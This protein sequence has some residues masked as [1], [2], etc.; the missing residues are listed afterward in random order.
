MHALHPL[1][2]AAFA[3]PIGAV[4]SRFEAFMAPEID[5]VDDPR[6]VSAFRDLA[7][8]TIV[9]AEQ[10]AYTSANQPFPSYINA[11]VSTDGAYMIVTVRSQAVRGDEADESPEA[12]C[13]AQIP[14]PI[15]E[16]DQFVAQATVIRQR[17]SD[18]P[19]AE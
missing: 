15:A 18:V 7:G 14:V 10:A 4:P 17:A 6:Y 9:R 3:G 8:D 12:G 5:W 19:P 11:T 13:T 16:W 2:G 1:R